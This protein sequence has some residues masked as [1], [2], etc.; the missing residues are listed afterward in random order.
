[1]VDDIKTVFEL[2][3]KYNKLTN[4][5]MIKVLE[6]VESNKLTEDL[7]SY[8]LSIM[9]LLNH[10]LHADIGWL[11]V[12]GTHIS[13][14]DFIP[15]LLERFPT[16]RL[17]PDKLYWKTLDEYKGVRSEID[18]MIE[19]TVKSLPASEYSTKIVVEGRR[20]KFEYI[21]WHILSHLFNHETHHRGGVS[22][23][24][25]QLNIENDYSSLLWKV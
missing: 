24:L 1:M 3:S 15:S 22:V 16:E 4:I 21:I 17:P 18:D 8:Y 13:S 25:D 5:D 2:F 6:G 23:L 11:R 19:R 20:G 14:L 9:G 7:G 12:L 10:Q